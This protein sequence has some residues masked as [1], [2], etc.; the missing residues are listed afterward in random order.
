M[1][2]QIALSVLC[3]VMTACS[4][5]TFED[6]NCSFGA[7]GSQG[8]TPTS[9]GDTDAGQSTGSQDQDEPNDDDESSGST[10]T[11]AATD[12]LPDSSSGGDM[13]QGDASTGEEAPCERVDF[14]FS[15]TPQAIEVP[16][17]ANYI[18]IKVWGAG[19]NLE[20]NCA[21]DAGVGGYTE[22]VLP[23]GDY[24]VLTVIVGEYGNYN[25]GAPE[26]KFGFGGSGGGGLSGVFS[27]GEELTE[28]D[29]A[30]ALVI[31]GGGGSAARNSCGP[32]VPGN[33]A[34]A[35][36][37]PNMHG[38]IALSGGGGGYQGG[39]AG[40]SNSRGVGGTGY[41]TPLAMDTILEA[42][43]PGTAAPPHADDV[44]YDGQAGRAEQ[45]GQ[46]IVNFVCD[47]PSPM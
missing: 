1:R 15:D 34:Q 12:P 33:H 25:S 8:S 19:G 39:T 16:S 47:Y 30:R 24:D 26:I 36:G 22:A 4:G 20:E 11:S 27:G 44:D 32:G 7:C 10:S 23:A 18:H 3:T 38:E 45:N 43:E 41:V 35:G 28:H 29:I 31:A 9:M 46:A 37:M 14:A 17:N 21:S 5:G 40:G 42:S 2:Q 13:S 6:P